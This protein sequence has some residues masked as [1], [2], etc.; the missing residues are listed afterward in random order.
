VSVSVSQGEVVAIVGAT[1]AGKTAFADALA[2]RLGGEVVN[3]DSMQVYRGMDIGTAK[4]PPAKRSVPY[5]CLDL[6]DPGVPFTAALYQRAARAAIDGLLARK[7][8]PVVC[9]GTGL[10]V[11][12]ALDDFRF[13]EGR[14]ESADVDA[15]ADEDA[16]TD[17][18]AGAD[19]DANATTDAVAAAA[20]DAPPDTATS[21]LRARLTAQ[22]QQQGADALYALL[23]ERDPESAALIHPHNV[24]RVIR[25][26]ELL[27]Q[28]TSYARQHEGF[29]RFESVYLTRFIGLAVEPEALYEVIERRVD[30]MMAAGLLDEVR[31][32]L[33][34][35]FR[36][37]ATA[38]QAIGYKE[39]VPVLEGE[40]SLE[41]AVAQ[42]KQATRRYA[43]RQRTWFKRDPRIQWIDA[44]DL[45]RAVLAGEMPS[46]GFALQLLARA[47]PGAA[48]TAHPFF[49]V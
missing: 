12:A 36:E 38:R 45:H 49:G 5:H 3:A 10:Y 27:E 11:R 15:G 40:Q 47:L 43:K 4:L 21:E 6:A 9:G 18:D 22:A 24:R 41:E 28:N 14:K 26:F 44:T 30:N 7:V 39:L 42:I 48:E 2:A 32:L 16:N 17:A 31:G 25:A 23:A 20:T 8:T 1:G 29:A 46:V 19:G 33:A 35:G 34:A 37:A 13:D